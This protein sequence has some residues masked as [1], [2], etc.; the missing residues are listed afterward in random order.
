MNLFNVSS[1]SNEMRFL[2]IE[3]L[4][5][6]KVPNSLK[7][8]QLVNISSLTLASLSQS[9]NTVC[10]SPQ[11]IRKEKYQPLNCGPFW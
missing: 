1:W 4:M 11:G 7:V 9:P 10:S 5:E 2:C 6:G 8:T 3:I